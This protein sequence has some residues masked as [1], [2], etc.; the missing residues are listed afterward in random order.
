MNAFRRHPWLSLGAIGS[1]LGAVL[2]VAA[3]MAGAEQAVTKAP[4]VKGTASFSFTPDADE[5][6]RTP[7]EVFS[8]GE[9]TVF[10]VCNEVEDDPETTEVDET[11]VQR[12]LLVTAGGQGAVVSTPDGSSVFAPGETDAILAEAVD[13]GVDT[14][15][16]LVQ[17]A[18]FDGSGAS[19]T[20]MAAVLTEVAE[21]RCTLTANVTG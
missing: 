9:S 12:F 3:G 20:G 13:N 6:G 19:A 14:G 15:A 21:N 11:G 8:V 2:V 10:V 7:H 18:I 1:V 17:F 16:A 5:A 4:N